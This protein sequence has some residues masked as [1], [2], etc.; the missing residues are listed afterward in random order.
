[1]P[2]RITDI[3]MMARRKHGTP[4]DGTRGTSD[5]VRWVSIGSEKPFENPF[6]YL[7]DERR[8]EFRLAK[9]NAFLN[10]VRNHSPFYRDRIP[11]KDLT[12]LEELDTLPILTPEELKANLP[13]KGSGILTAPLK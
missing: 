7:P 8:E 1:M 11:A 2:D 10:Y 13:P 12:S 9:L 6:D 3:G 4:H 5:M